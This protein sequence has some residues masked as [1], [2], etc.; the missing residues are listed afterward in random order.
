MQDISLY[1]I[2]DIED[3][4]K[5]GQQMHACPYYSSRRA[6]QSAEVVVLP[7][8]MLLQESTRNFLGID[9]TNQVVVCDEAHNVID[10]IS[11]MHSCFITRG[12]ISQAEQEL[13][14]YLVKYK[15]RFDLDNAQTLSELASVAHK[16]VEFAQNESTNRVWSLDSF[17]LA[18]RLADNNL[19]ELVSAAQ[20]S[21]LAKKLK[22]IAKELAQ[23]QNGEKKKNSSSAPPPLLDSTMQRVLQ[24]L[25][26]LNSKA[27]DGR[28]H[29]LPQPQDTNQ[30]SFKFLL[31]NPGSRF[32]KVVEKAHSVVL[33]GGTMHPVDD[34]IQQLFGTYPKDQIDLFSC[35]HVIPDSNILALACRAGPSARELKLTFE[36][37]SDSKV[38][39]EIGLAILSLCRIVPHGLVVFFPSYAFEEELCKRLDVA[40]ILNEIVACKPL[41]REKNGELVL[42]KYAELVNTTTDGA[43][44]FAVVGGK[45]SEGINFSDNL[46]RC[47][48]VVGLPYASKTDPELNAKMAYMGEPLGSRYYENLCWRG[49]NQ[50][51][52][53]AIRHAKDYAAIVLLDSRY[54]QAK[55]KSNLPTWIAKRYQVS[56]EWASAES[57]LRDFFA[58]ERV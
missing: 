49:I 41:V 16:L 17:L 2:H 55:A 51:I 15:D 11:D 21:R 34:L 36:T 8:T 24:F 48:C 46:A 28:I 31:L 22:G 14:L 23:Q 27:I 53:R 32:A 10:A 47:V 18:S 37:R 7:Y 44:L 1:E 3:L 4:V 40:G 5:R 50:S 20:Q 54:T 30:S 9:L 12:Q 25:D 57:Q 42:E 45:L 33:A 29:F 39:D 35:G 58:L 52:G 13:R 43:V 26:S 38:T 6:L 19:F 56:E